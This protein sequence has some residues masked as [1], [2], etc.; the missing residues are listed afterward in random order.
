MIT[1]IHPLVQEIPPDFDIVFFRPLLVLPCT[2]REE[3]KKGAFD[4]SGGKKVLC[5]DHLTV[6]VAEKKLKRR[7]LTG[8]GIT[9]GGMKISTCNMHPRIVGIAS[10]KQQCQPLPMLLIEVPAPG[11]GIDRSE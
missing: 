11:I 2:E 1:G 4:A 9:S 6:F 5:S 8:Q 3:R 10:E 7:Y